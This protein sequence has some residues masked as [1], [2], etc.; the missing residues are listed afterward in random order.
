MSKKPTVL[1]LSPWLPDEAKAIL[2]A[3]TLPIYRT[4]SRD[5]MLADI[6]KADAL[7]PHF[8]LKV[9]RETLDRA[10]N[11]KVINCASTGTDHIDKAAIAARGITLLSLAK[12]VGLLRTFTATAE[13][14]WM[15]TMA[16]FRHVRAATRAAHDGDWADGARRFEGRQLYGKTL[17]VLGIG[18]LGRM[19]VEFGKG[20]GMRVQGCDVQPFDIDGVEPVDFDT[21]LATSDAISIHIHMTPE[22]HHLFDAATLAKVK[23]G[24]VIANT[25][26]GDIIDEAAMIDA[27]ESGQVAA[28]G[29]D[30]VHDEWRPDMRENL[31]V[32][33]ATDHDH[34][35][36]TPHIGGSTIESVVNARVFSARKLAHYLQTGEQLAMA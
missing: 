10:P 3:A 28:Y 31:L 4:S 32:H 11:L 18:R 7:W 6:D 9:D 1:V 5:A 36:L 20:F 25:S 2:E 34:V 12:D 13:L 23:S 15:F 26:R 8:D 30:V 17:G 19:T 27:L 29:A 33:Y 16:G 24:V 22:N 21:L 14:S 35:T